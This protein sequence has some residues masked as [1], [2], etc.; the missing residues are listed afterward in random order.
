MILIVGGQKGGTGKS[1]LSTNLAV[2]LVRAGKRPLL[3]D[4][5]TQRSSSNWSDVRETD[6]SLP[7]I[8]TT[9]KTGKLNGHLP[10]MAEHFEHLVVDAG[11]RDSIELRSALLV[12]DRLVIPI[13]PSQID[14]WTLD[15]MSELV[16]SATSLNLKLTA[17][18]LIT[19]V[20]TNPMI[21]ELAESRELLSQYPSLGVC[22]TIIHE[23]KA[24]RDVIFRGKGV[25][26]YHDPKAA[27]EIHSLTQ[28]VFEHEQLLATA[29]A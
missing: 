8:T 14:L 20:P 18:L 16:E 29:T 9:Q 1:T 23:R 19:L 5:D 27:A 26:E 25:V 22:T 11:G 12:A 21:R 3:V 15:A 24:Y 10:K 7:P 13:R 6:A 28:E 17:A 2:A 4:T